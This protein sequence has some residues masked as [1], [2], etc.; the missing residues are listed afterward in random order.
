M[1]LKKA[2]MYRE[3]YTPEDARNCR[4]ALQLS[5]CHGCPQSPSFHFDFCALSVWPRDVPSTF[6]PTGASP[7]LSCSGV[8][9]ISQPACAER[10]FPGAAVFRFLDFLAVSTSSSMP[11]IVLHLA[12]VWLVSSNKDVGEWHS[13]KW[14]PTNS[15]FFFFPYSQRTSLGRHWCTLQ[16]GRA[17]W[18]WRGFCSS[19]QEEEELSASTTATARRPWAWPWRGATRS[20]I[21]FWPS[22]DDFVVPLLVFPL[23]CFPLLY[24]W[25][26]SNWGVLVGGGWLD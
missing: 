22:K 8:S 3:M 4:E 20:C 9:W 24:P 21:S 12:C 7:S 11:A 26:V 6:S 5:G 10:V 17:C 25:R 2:W 13:P 16:W 1:G 18:G 23:S 19:S 14:Q 15:Y